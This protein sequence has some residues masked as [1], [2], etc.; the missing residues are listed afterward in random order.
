MLEWIGKVFVVVILSRAVYTD[1]REGKIEN[2]LIAAGLVM[3]IVTACLT[4]GLDRLLL[5]VRQSVLVML[6]M[7][8]LFVIKGLGAGDIKLLSVLAVF[9][10][11]KILS[12]IVMAFLTA[13]AF[14]VM[15][16]LV[17]FCRKRAM[18]KKREALHFSVPIAVGIALVWI[19]E[20]V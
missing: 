6:S 14:I 19:A 16:M 11:E 3:G 20:W 17:R 10:P 15:R 13:A 9:M 12:V 4:G 1:I 8:I 2:S 18:F 7:F 5:S